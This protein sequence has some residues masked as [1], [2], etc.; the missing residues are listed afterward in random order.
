MCLMPQELKPCKTYDLEG[1]NRRGCGKSG[2]PWGGGKTAICFQ[3]CNFPLVL[4]TFPKV[5][6]CRPPVKPQGL[7]PWKTYD[8]EGLK[9]RGCSKGGAPCGAEV[10]QS[11]GSKNV[12]APRFWRL[13][14]NWVFV[15]SLK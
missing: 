6:F 1:L 14:Q 3:K 9:R 7:K 12:V 11:F 15:G 5:G 13:F 2:A 8:L 4:D 10:K